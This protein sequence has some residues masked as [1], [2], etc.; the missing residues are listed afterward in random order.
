[1]SRMRVS[2]AV[3]A[4]CI[5]RVE[6]R[7]TKGERKCVEL[8]ARMCGYTFSETPLPIAEPVEDGQTSEME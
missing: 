2:H 5:S 6:R 1:M 8:P 4:R 3:Y 7:T